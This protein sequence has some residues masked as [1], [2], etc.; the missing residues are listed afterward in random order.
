MWL[1]ILPSF[2][3]Q[4]LV[5]QQNRIHSTAPHSILACADWTWGMWRPPSHWHSHI[6]VLG[7]LLW[8]PLDFI[9]QLGIAESASPLRNG[10]LHFAT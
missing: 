7:A 10:F 4:K 2:A 3:T 8:L 9:P 1:F 6:K 5:S